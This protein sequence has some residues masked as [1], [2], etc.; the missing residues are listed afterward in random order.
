M[1]IPV[2][3]GQPLF[4]V[5]EVVLRKHGYGRRFE[6]EE[7]SLYSS[8][9]ERRHFGCSWWTYTLRPL[10]PTTE[11]LHGVQERYLV[12]VPAVDRLAEL[13]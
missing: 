4:S 10:P 3:A 2:E 1:S 6:I 11:R 9:D 7:V 8:L 13:V 5:G 12:A